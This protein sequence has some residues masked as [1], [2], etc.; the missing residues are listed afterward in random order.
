MRL[1]ILPFVKL[2]LEGKKSVIVFVCGD[3]VE[4]LI[5]T[6]FENSVGRY[7]CPKCKKHIYVTVKEGYGLIQAKSYSVT[8]EWPDR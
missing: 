4:E 6:Q 2:S 3:C 8:D 5:Y 1:K 7:L